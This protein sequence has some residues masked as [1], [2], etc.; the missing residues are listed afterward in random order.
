MRRCQRLLD[1]RATRRREAGL[2]G[3]DLRAEQLARPLCIV[4]I[5]DYYIYYAYIVCISADES[6]TRT[7]GLKSW[8]ELKPNYGT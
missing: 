1:A 3:P 8:Q 4:C 5:G 2:D 7:G 6:R